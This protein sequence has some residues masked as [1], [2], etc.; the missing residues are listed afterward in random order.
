MFPP[1]MPNQTP[2]QIAR[3]A[4]DAQ[5]RASGWAAQNK[6]DINLRGGQ[7]MVIHVHCHLITF[8]LAKLS[9]RT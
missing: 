9:P 8:P 5:L 3:G 4:I 1:A 7:S 6:N 2:E